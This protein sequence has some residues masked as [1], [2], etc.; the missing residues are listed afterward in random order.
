MIK[1]KFQIDHERIVELLIRNDAIL[2][3]KNVYG[4]TAMDVATEKGNYF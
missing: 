1:T 2:S 3:V 4:R